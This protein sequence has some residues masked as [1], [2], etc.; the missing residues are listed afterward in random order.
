MYYDIC[1]NKLPPLSSKNDYL[2]VMN[3]LK[4]LTSITNDIIKLLEK[5]IKEKTVLNKIIIESF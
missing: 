4:S 5:G 3:R 2:S 1:I